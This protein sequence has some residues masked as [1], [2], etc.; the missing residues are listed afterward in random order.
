MNGFHDF[1]GRWP[2]VSSQSE[3]SVSWKTA[4]SVAQDL[5]GLSRACVEGGGNPDGPAAIWEARSVNARSG[6]TLQVKGCPGCGS[7]PFS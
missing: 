2:T 4:P 1:N 3:L 6:G 5:G 7:L